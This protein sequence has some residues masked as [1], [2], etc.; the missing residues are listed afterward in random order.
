M[1]VESRGQFSSM[2]FR[3]NKARQVGTGIQIAIVNDVETLFLNH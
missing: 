1:L 2:F 3:L